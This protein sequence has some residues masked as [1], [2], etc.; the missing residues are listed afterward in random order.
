MIQVLDTC[1]AASG[2]GLLTIL[3]A[4]VAASGADSQ[5]I[6]DVI[7][8]RIAL[9]RSFAMVKD[10]SWG[11]RGGRVSI[12][13]KRI[14]DWL[15]LRIILGNTEDGRLKAQGAILA[16]QNS[17]PGF[18]R[19]LLKRMDANTMYRLVISHCACPDDAKRL[20]D[21][22]LSQHDLIDGCWITTTGPAVGVHVGPGSLVVGIQE[23]IPWQEDQPKV[24]KRAQTSVESA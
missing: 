15:R 11:V 1:N 21:A 18:A 16:R 5:R 24:K 3:A 2:H 8:E 12:W 9:T 13:A 19:W 10:L 22:I 14:A 23:H 7:N 17:I 20:R 6:V 4:E